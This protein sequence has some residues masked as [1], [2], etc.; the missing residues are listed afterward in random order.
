MKTYRPFFYHKIS[1]LFTHKTVPLSETFCKL[2]NLFQQFSVVFCSYFSVTQNRSFQPLPLKTFSFKHVSAETFNICF[3]KN[4]PHCVS[5]R[6]YFLFF[7]IFTLS[8]ICPDLPLSFPNSG[9]V[10][11]TFCRSFSRGS[12]R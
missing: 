1:S 5:V 6:G 3:V 9:G 8:A 4:T 12:E 11:P 2:S 10:L 7:P